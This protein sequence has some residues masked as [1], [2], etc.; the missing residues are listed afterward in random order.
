MVEEKKPVATKVVTKVHKTAKRIHKKAAKVSHK[1]TKKQAT[2]RLDPAHF[3]V[4]CFA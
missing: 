2:S 3:V 4:I 1:K